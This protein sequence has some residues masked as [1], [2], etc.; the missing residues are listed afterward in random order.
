M[1][2]HYPLQPPPHHDLIHS[3]LPCHSTDLGLGLGGLLRLLGRRLLLRGGLGGGGGTGSGDGGRGGSNLLHD[4]CGVEWMDEW[5]DW[6]VGVGGN[7]RNG[8]RMRGAG[9]M[10]GWVDVMDVGVERERVSKSGRACVAW[11]GC[12]DG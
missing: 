4:Q 10:G 9:R 2:I 12:M 6:G 3:F 5:M 11:G 1:Y 7:R 8:G